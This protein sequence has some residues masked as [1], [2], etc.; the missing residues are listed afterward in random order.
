[1]T[2]R[3]Q[4]HRSRRARHRNVAVCPSLLLSPSA[5]LRRS[6]TSRRQV[7]QAAPD[8]RRQRLRQWLG[9][10]PLSAN[11]NA[12]V[13]FFVLFSCLCCLKETTHRSGTS[14]DDVYAIRNI[15]DWD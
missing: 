12:C 7:F 9:A 15:L 1:M 3:R 2:T 8:V 14:F 5:I 13:L 6:Q 10:V 11:A 4:R